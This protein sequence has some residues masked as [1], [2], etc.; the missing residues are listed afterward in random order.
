MEY[1]NYLFSAVSVMAMLGCYPAIGA[2]TTA[3]ISS[4]TSS[5][6]SSS[7]GGRAIEEVVVH[8][9]PFARNIN[10]VA[11]PVTSLEGDDLIRKRRATLGDTLESQP[12]IHS[13]TFGAGSSRPVIRGQ[14]APRVKVLSDGVEV[15]DASSVSPD[16]AISGEPLLLEKIEVLRGPSAL[17]YGGGAIGG[18][19]NLIDKK[20][21][22]VIPENTIDA[23]IEL[24]GG[25]ADDE[26]TGVA[27]VTVG[28]GNFAFRME[29]V[30]RRS[31]DYRVPKWSERHVDGTYNDSSTA[32]LG[33]SWVG[34]SGYFG[35]AYTR[36]N[37]EYGLPGHSHE[38]EACH[39][40]GSHLHCGGHD[41]DHDDDD[42]DHDHE[43]EGHDVPIVDL[44][45]DRFDVRGEYRNPFAGIERVR[46]RAGFTDY[47]HDEIDDGVVS[48]TF[49]NKGY[50][51]RLEME[52]ADI[53]ALHG[54]FGVQT[55]KS[56]FSA[57]GLESFLPKTTTKSTGLF[58]LEE[59]H[60]GNWRLEAAVRQEWY[61]IEPEAPRAPLSFSPF[62]V[63]G[64]A[65]WT[66]NAEFSVALS[67]ARSERAPNAQ[68]LFARGV[69]LATNTFEIGDANLTKET[70]K[71]IDLTLR[72]RGGPLTFSVSVYHNS[73]DDYIFAQTLDQ[74]EEFR[75]IRYAQQDARFTGIDGE[76]AYQFSP[77]LRTEVFGDYVRAKFKNNG[78]DLPRIPNA[79]LGGRLI[80]SWQDFEGDLEYYHAFRQSDIAAFETETNGYDMVNATLAYNLSFAGADGQIYLRGTNLLNKLAFNHTS[81][82]KNST[83][84]MGRNFV[85][86]VRATF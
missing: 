51:A 38:Y 31:D 72:K 46:L 8:G 17:L 3:D 18:A 79:R 21:P 33:A 53:G 76:I 60:L 50:D 86:G 44:R 36:Q 35:V 67:A 26:R 70:S 20:I 64:A 83:P 2:E 25:T 71:S 15:M 43:E 4:E 27:G 57:V 1:R 34:E 12:G 80:G 85:L 81:F 63:S 13:D 56:K 11:A 65:I 28:E 84:L 77:A 32:S 39:P 42:H 59:L 19:V 7:G 66:I 16:H 69:H 73:V 37:S 5:A 10:D 54:V 22:T 30:I 47:A 68:E 62:S 9:L 24:R 74:Y 45:T 40:H 52:H 78:G 55:N 41:H 14:T 49:K 75:L 58:L 82:I 61:D 29:G 23:S 48:T 6:Q